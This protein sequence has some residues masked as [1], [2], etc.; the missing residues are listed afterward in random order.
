MCYK[1]FRAGIVGSRK[2]Q[3]FTLFQTQTVKIYAQFQARRAQKPQPLGPPNLNISVSN[4][5][6]NSH[7]IG[8]YVAP[9]HYFCVISSEFRLRLLT[10]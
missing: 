6:G 5:I 7:Y 8:N 9:C 2:A 4:P 1:T 3:N 10:F